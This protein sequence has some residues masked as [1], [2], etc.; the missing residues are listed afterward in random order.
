[1]I[2][3]YLP[4]I[5]LMLLLSCDGAQKTAEV[6]EAKSEFSTE[7]FLEE[8]LQD[9]FSWSSDR[10]PLVSAHRGGPYSGYPENALET[11]ENILSYTPA[12]IECD[13]AITKDSVLVLMHDNTLDR[14]TDGT[15]KV[16]DKTWAEIQ[17]LFLV[18]NDGLT[19]NYK[20]PTLDETL[21][22]GYGKALFT[23]DVKR[24]VPFE[25]VVRAVEKHN[26]GDFAAIITY[27]ANAAQEVHQLNPDLMISVGLGSPQAYEAHKSK[28]I[29]DKNMIA[30]V[31]TREPE[32][33]HFDFLHEKGIS[34]IL[35][36]LGNLDRQAI[37]K[38]DSTYLGFVN[39]GADVLATDRPIEAARTIRSLWPKTSDKYKFI[40]Q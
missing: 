39:R 13:I 4:L 22:W 28:G 20:V 3:Q 35:G 30:F 10:I 24:G 11:F 7:T 37:A 40:T 17:E 14:T 5:F 31:G 32:Q 15:G 25:M 23:L 2:R 27:N 21:K 36:V 34:T 12:V 26:M 1:M 8:G 38:G 9:F 33:T 16:S 18:D 6:I 29:P 19:T